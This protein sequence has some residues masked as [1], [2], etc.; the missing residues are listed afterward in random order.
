MLQLLYFAST[1]PVNRLNGIEDF[2]GDCHEAGTCV[3]LKA[4]SAELKDYV[5]HVSTDAYPVFPWFPSYSIVVS[6]PIKS[7]HMVTDASH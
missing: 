1:Q 7:L 6:G 3:K 2:G 5:V 4:A